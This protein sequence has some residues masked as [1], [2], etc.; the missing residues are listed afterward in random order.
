LQQG[1][2]FYR[3][4]ITGNYFFNYAKGGG[5]QARI[6]AAKFGYMGARNFTAYLY[7]PKLLAANGTEDYTYNNYFMGRT[8]ST[9]FDR[10]AVKNDGIAAQQVM[11]QN[12]GGLK[13]RLDQYSSVQ[14][15]SEKWVAAFNLTS[16]LPDK[17]FPVK[18]PLKIF[19]DAGTYAEAWEKNAFT[20]RFLYV[21]GL[22]LSLFKNVI[23]I[24]APII[25]SKTFK[26][27]L[28]TDKEANKFTKKITF[29]FDIQ[30]LSL[31][32]LIPQIP[33]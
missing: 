3:I 27:Q 9:A 1:D 33:F 22:Q 10:I 16:T 24:Y 4:N 29:S 23:N 12:T 15:Y 13:L 5:L 30:N 2:G 26:E 21:G 31:R 32:K 8:A 14:G 25:Y 6:F 7:Q 20:P 11:I 19:F 17:L 28:K 18:L